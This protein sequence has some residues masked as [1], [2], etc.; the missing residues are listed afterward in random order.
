MLDIMTSQNSHFGL[1]INPC[2]NHANSIKVLKKKWGFT[3]C[4]AEQPL[5]R[6]ELQ[7]K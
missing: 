3:P 1:C 2:H 4:K 7:E 6:I 5:Q